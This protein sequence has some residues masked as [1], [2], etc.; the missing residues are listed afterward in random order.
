VGG[1][2][3]AHNLPVFLLLHGERDCVCS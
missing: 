2:K 1:N 3:D